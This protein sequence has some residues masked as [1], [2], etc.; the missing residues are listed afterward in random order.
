MANPS[1]SLLFLKKLLIY[2]AILGIFSFLAWFIFPQKYFSPAL[3]FIF[4]FFIAITFLEYY[5]LVRSSKNK[6]VRFINTYLLITTLKLL[7][8]IAI[9]VI[10]ILLYKKDAVPFGLSFF[11]L[12]LFYTIFEVV[13]LINFSKNSGK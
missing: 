8:F 7:L 11:V 9:L 3:P 10:Y 6:I 1:S 4:I 13:S 2:S 5:F 12:Y